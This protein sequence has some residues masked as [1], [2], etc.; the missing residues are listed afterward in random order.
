MALYDEIQS[1]F[2]VEIEKQ[3][4]NSARGFVFVTLFSIKDI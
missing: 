4:K 1:V 2:A 3:E